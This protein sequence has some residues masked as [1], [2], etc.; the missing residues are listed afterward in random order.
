MRPL[1]VG[2]PAPSRWHAGFARFCCP[3]FGTRFARLLKSPGF[4]TSINHLPRL[5]CPISSRCTTAWSSSAW[6]KR[7]CPPAG[8]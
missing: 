5:P 8:S 2:G 7:S 6:K 1:K 3:R 4:S